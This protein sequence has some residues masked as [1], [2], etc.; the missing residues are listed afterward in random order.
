MCGSI[1]KGLASF[2]SRGQDKLLSG[3]EIDAQVGGSFLFVARRDGK[4]RG[5]N[6]A[7]PQQSLRA[8]SV[9]YVLGTF[10]YPCLRG[11][12]QNNGEPGG[13]RTRDHRIKSAV[14]VHHVSIL[15]KAMTHLPDSSQHT[16]APIFPFMVPVA[17]PMNAL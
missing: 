13:A 4:D 14:T 15:C 6:S 8:K 2:C 11:G 12:H 5:K 17:V 16:V 3:A 9:T 10:C 7:A 1:R